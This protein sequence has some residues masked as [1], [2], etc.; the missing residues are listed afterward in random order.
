M[1]RKK[2]NLFFIPKYSEL[3]F[4]SNT[5]ILLFLFINDEFFRNF[6]IFDVLN[7]GD[8]RVLIIF[9]FFVGGMVVSIYNFFILR[10]K[11]SFEKSLLAIYMLFSNFFLLFYFFLNVEMDT[12][13]FIIF[14]I[15][16]IYYSLIWLLMRFVI[17]EDDLVLDDDV[18]IKF[19]IFYTVFIFFVVFV[20]QVFL[21]MKWEQTYII[22]N[23]MIIFLS[24]IYRIFIYRKKPR[25]RKKKDL[26]KT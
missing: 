19:A 20:F 23:F 3:H 26:T 12:F 22:L 21:R 16:L 6:I 25:K 15:N 18:N 11:N 13:Y 5:I 9:L 2:S 17:D 14:I 8:L 4:F 7:S 24:E 10:K 1:K